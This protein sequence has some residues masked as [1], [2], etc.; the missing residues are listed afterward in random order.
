[1]NIFTCLWKS[2]ADAFCVATHRTLMLSQMILLAFM[3]YQYSCKTEK[4]GKTDNEKT[5]IIWYLKWIKAEAGNASIVQYQFLAHYCGQVYFKTQFSARPSKHYT[6]SSLIWERREKNTLFHYCIHFA[7]RHIHSRHFQPLTQLSTD[8]HMYEH[9]HRAGLKKQLQFLIKTLLIPLCKTQLHKYT[10][11][12]K[13][14][15]RDGRKEE[16]QWRKKM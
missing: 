8:T 1:M 14:R 15:M 2:A 5:S 16:R 11:W 13:G 12:E 4:F 7:L 3:P 6:N 10:Q 9:I